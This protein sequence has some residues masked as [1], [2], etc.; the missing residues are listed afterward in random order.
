MV[1]DLKAGIG[2]LRQESR[3]ESPKMMIAGGDFPIS[4]AFSALDCCALEGRERAE[5]AFLAD[6]REFRLIS[7]FSDSGGMAGSGSEPISDDPG[8]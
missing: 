7:L 2:P 6:M 5:L 4:E 3:H 8:R 1:S